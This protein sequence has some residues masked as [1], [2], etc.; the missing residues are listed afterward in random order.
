MTKILEKLKNLEKP[1]FHFKPTKE[2]YDFTGINRK[3][4]GLIISGRIEPTF[5]EIKSIADFFKM[6]VSEFIN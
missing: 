6:E 3:R 5:K 4:F 2:L 1:C